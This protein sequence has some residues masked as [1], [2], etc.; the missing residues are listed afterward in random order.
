MRLL[1]ARHRQRPHWSIPFLIIFDLGDFVMS[2]PDSSL[3]QIHRFDLLPAVGIMSLG[4]KRG[5][6]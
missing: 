5:K 3:Q 2:A 1:I 4:G 6:K